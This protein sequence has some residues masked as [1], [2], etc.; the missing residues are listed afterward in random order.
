[1][2]EGGEDGDGREWRLPGLLYV[3]ELVLCGESEEDLGMMGW[4]FEVYR[5]GLKINAVKSKVMVLNGEEGLQCEVHIDWFQNSKICVLGE[6]GTD[7]AEC[8]RR[9]A[10]AIRSLVNARDFQLDCARVLHEKLLVPV[11]IYGTETMLWKEKERSTIRAVQMDNLR[12][13]LGIGRMD[14]VLN[15]RI[16]DLCRM[17]KWVD[18]RINEG[19]FGHEERME[20]DGIAKRVY[21]G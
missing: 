7:G 19:G 12:G 1:M 13:L 10:G 11:L 15:S 21:V 20:N 9:V 3:D 18:E 6:S 4:F 5:K 2:D 17:R 14:R 8:S 16:R